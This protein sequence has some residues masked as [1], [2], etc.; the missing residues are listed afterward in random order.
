MSGYI[1]VLIWM[2]IMAFGA[3]LRNTKKYELVNG[4]K[5]QRTQMQFAILTFLPVILWAGFRSGAGYADTNAYIFKYKLIPRNIADFFE[6]LGTVEKDVGFEVFTGIIKFIFGSN[7]TPYLMIIAIIQ[8]GIIIA[9]YRKY[10]TNYI[11]SIFLFIATTEYFSWM[12]NGIRQFLAVTIVIAATPLMLKKKYIELIL[13]IVLAATIHQTA[14]IMIP[15]VFIAQGK[16]WNRKTI[17]LIILVIGVLLYVDQFTDFLDNALSETQYSATVSTWQEMGDDG[18]NPIRVLVYAIPTLIALFG[19]KQLAA[20]STPIIN[21][22]INMSIISSAIYLVSMVTSGIMIGRL[23]I[24]V[25]LYSYILLPYE[26]DCIFAK[27]SAKIVKLS[28][29]ICY[30]LYYYYLMHFAYGKI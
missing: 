14:L 22:S 16:P 20:K 15:I 2:A 9:F 10:S 6:Y 11:L 4:I 30:L 17:A 12:F 18:S 5:E 29:V 27:Q 19:R 13:I 23:P 1:F 3:N 21:L 26:I 24:Y 25:S 7:Y 8:G 28:L